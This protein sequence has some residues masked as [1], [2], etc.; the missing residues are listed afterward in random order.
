M[1]SSGRSRA[2]RVKSTRS[3]PI[4]RL[5]LNLLFLCYICFGAGPLCK[6]DTAETRYAFV[7]HRFESNKSSRITFTIPVFRDFAKTSYVD[8]RL[9][10]NKRNTV[11]YLFVWI[12]FTPFISNWSI[13]CRPWYPFRTTYIHARGLF[14]Y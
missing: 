10:P 7:I 8:G 1:K 3:Q 6:T 13:Y 14:D 4:R 9:L 5:L 2:F 12:T 11:E